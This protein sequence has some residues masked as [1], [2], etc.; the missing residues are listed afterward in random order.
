MPTLDQVYQYI[1][2]TPFETRKQQYESFG[3]GGAFGD[4]RGTTEQN[5]TLYNK[6][7]SGGATVP[8]GSAERTKQLLEQG[9]VLGQQAS[10]I[11]GK[12]FEPAIFGVQP[13]PPPP[14][15]QDV[16]SETTPTTTQNI[17]DLLFEQAKKGTEGETKEATF[18]LAAATTRGAK[19]IQRDVGTLQRTAQEGIAELGLAGE[20]KQAQIGEQ[21]AGFGGAFSGVTKKSQAEIAQEVA[22]KQTSIRAKLGDSLYNA[23][24]DFEKNFGTKFLESLSIPEAEQ[25]TKLPI[26][27]RGIVMQNYQ[28]AI[29]KAEEK[30]QKI[31]LGT[32]EKL[33]YTVVGGQIVQ[34]LA[35]RREERIATEPLTPTTAQKEYE[36]AL[37]QG[38]KGSFLDYQKLK[39]TQFGTEG[40][41]KEPKVAPSPGFFDAKIEGSVREDFVS[42]K[43]Q[44][45]AP[46]E[47]Y[48]TLRTLYSPQEVND[49]ALKDLV[50]IKEE[51]PSP[52]GIADEWISEGQGFFE[53]LKLIPRIFK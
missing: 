21:A 4:F 15:A 35:G 41:T 44:G 38:F 36:F 40:T 33:G 51:L 24:S 31:A 22:T 19:T 7:L 17:Y 28:E 52:E 16:I 37:T 27:V 11:T 1:K 3:L 26:Q 12:T 34:T 29:E 9:N 48:D 18:D 49:Q 10:A 8:L 50:G 20:K 46:A 23:F 42:L 39:A 6:T 13:P 14:T 5:T 2:S 25:F 53:R 45:K 47:T 32:L 43:G 30:A